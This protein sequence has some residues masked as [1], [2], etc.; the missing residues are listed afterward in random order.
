M[1]VDKF[2]KILTK[3]KKHNCRYRLYYNR[4]ITF[5]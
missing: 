2:M 3:E 4:H 1:D 5:G